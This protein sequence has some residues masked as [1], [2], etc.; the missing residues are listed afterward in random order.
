VQ[1]T[2]SWIVPH[3]FANLAENGTIIAHETGRENS[4]GFA[5]V[6]LSNIFQMFIDSFLTG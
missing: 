6:S 1:K 4:S 5:A 3:R 2:F